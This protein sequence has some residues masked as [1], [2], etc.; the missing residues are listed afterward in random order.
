MLPT[1][2][3]PLMV[4]LGG[5]SYGMVST[6]VKL[7]YQQGFGVDAVTGCQYLLAFLGLWLGALLVPRIQ[8]SAKQRL[9]LIAAGI[10][11]GLTG[12]FYNQALLYVDA[13]V[14]II[15]LMQ[16]TWITM[17]IKYVYE[18]VVPKRHHCVAV[19]IILLGSVLASGFVQ[20]SIQVSWLGVGLGLLSALSSALFLYFSGSV[21]LMLHPLYKAALMTTGALLIVV[22]WMPPTFMDNMELLQG[23]LPYSAVAA[24]FASVL[25]VILFNF[26]MPKVGNLGSILT[27]SELPMAVFM[28]TVVLHE[29][30]SRVQWLGMVVVLLGIVY[31]NSKKQPE[32]T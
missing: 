26:S 29:S 11:M 5:C 6:F 27:A 8:L 24:V 13:S 10:P 7:A 16:F 3:H 12:I 19:V 32:F 31:A 17:V 22:V 25:P 30:V 28:S 4:F 9:V 18:H 2:L 21:G 23:V 15:L 20:S 14:A 1:I